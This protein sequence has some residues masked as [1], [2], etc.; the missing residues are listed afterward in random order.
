MNH[1]H[2]RALALLT[3]VLCLLPA[4]GKKG[5]EDE[6]VSSLPAEYTMG[7]NV[8]L[9]LSTE[10]DVS[11]KEG[12]IAFFTYG[13]LANAGSTAESYVGQMTS[14]EEGAGF[15][16]VD[17][18]F[19]RTSDR[20]DFTA[21][22][23]EILLAKNLE[24]PE[25]EE[26]S[27]DSEEETVPPPDMVLTLRVAWAESDCVVTLQEREGRVTSPPPAPAQSQAS[28]MD[29]QEAIDY[30]RSFEPAELGLPGSS[31]DTYNIYIQDGVVLVDSMPCFRMNV[32]GTDN[33]GQTN[34]Y[35]GSYLMTADGLYL[36]R[37]NPIADTI[38]TIKKP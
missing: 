25:E 35:A 1:K 21:A 30:F 3:A 24:P 2:I 28:A 36:Y 8:V 31:M 12:H 4:C 10:E 19:V 32:Y 15:S 38:E 17:E 11:L 29:T 23:G 27:E 18:E 37:L 26:N 33:P 16:V 22:G 9:A 20:P 7:D 6:P 5:E 13:G 14:R 34:E